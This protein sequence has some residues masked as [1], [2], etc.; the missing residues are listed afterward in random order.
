MTAEL[1]LEN[2]LSFGPSISQLSALQHEIQHKV[3]HKIFVEFCAG[4]GGA[5]AGGAGIGSGGGGGGIGG[6][7]NNNCISSS[8]KTVY[9]VFIKSISFQ[10]VRY[11]FL[12][13]MSS[14]SSNNVTQYVRPFIRP[15]V[16]FFGSCVYQPSR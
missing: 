8:L 10:M 3:M 15:S 7:C 13:A 5:V 4:G 14:S 1:L 11:E 16:S 9:V 2:T 6:R 12:A